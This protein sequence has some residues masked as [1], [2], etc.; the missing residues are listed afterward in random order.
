MEDFKIMYPVEDEVVSNQNGVEEV[1]L[2]ADD[3]PALAG[4]DG[5]PP[6]CV[7]NECKRPFKERRCPGMEEVGGQIMED[8]SV[9]VWV[10]C[11]WKEDQSYLV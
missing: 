4:E 6:H 3:C 7:I 8:G 11:N 5:P 1:G 2:Y 9:R 10:A